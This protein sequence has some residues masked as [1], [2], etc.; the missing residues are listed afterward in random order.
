MGGLVQ[1]MATGLTFRGQS[2]G[3]SDHKGSRAKYWQPFKLL[4]VPWF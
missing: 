3:K 4:T 2:L 1:V